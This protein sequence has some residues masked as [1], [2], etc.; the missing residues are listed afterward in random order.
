MAFNSYAYLL[1]LVPVVALYWALPLRARLPYIIVASL[2]YYATWYAAYLPL[3]VAVCAV[4]LACGR[5]I[6]TGGARKRLWLK[7]G[8]AFA[9][10][11]LAFFKYRLFL[12]GLV[13]PLLKAA[14]L[15]TGTALDL[16]L[17]LGISF[18]IFE[19][20]SYL[21]DTHQGRVTKPA[22]QDL[23]GF[24]LFWPNL[25]AGPI[26]RFR[27][28]VPQFAKERRFEAG[29]ALRG[30]DRLLLGLLQKNLF[31][32][33]LG[34]LL[35]EGFAPAAALT[36]STIDNWA[37]AVGFGLQIYF[38]FASYSNMA[39]GAA[40]LIGITLPENFRHPYHAVTPP[41]FWT[42]WHMTL[43]RWI[44]DYLFF[45]LN[46]RYGGAPLPLYVSLVAIMGLVG[47]WHG[48]GWGFIVWGMLHGS[49]L[50]VYRVW[51]SFT[52]TR[53]PLAE[54]PLARLGWRA[55]TLLAV[56]AAWVPFRARTL[57]QAV[58]MF[59]TMLV[60]PSFHVSFGVNSYLII[61]LLGLYA[62]LEPWLEGRLHAL[63][64]SAGAGRRLVVVR[65]VVRPA[66]YA[67]ALFLFLSFDDQ[68]RQFIYFQF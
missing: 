59:R 68:D 31:A 16:A 6:E 20:I 36:N 51:E 48:A 33:T 4:T 66:L 22:F 56:T 18:F 15:S 23:L 58:T 9:L 50:V 39:I 5:R 2:G 28:L 29:M 34:G 13:A 53:K 52:A 47:L 62:L 44:R 11:I 24:V 60:R 54:A 63:E 45:P 38:D 40:Q 19:C 61:A 57:G 41:E 35:D 42:R 65:Y 43:S 32:N 12:L 55:F 14:G 3:P 10:L 7:L 1:L 49:Y 67:L 30:L 46:A 26:V 27:E 8:I 64:A 21:L 17:P 25:M 37:L